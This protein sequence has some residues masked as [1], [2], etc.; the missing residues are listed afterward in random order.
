MKVKW[1]ATALRDVSAHVAYLDQFN[2]H[3]ARELAA[4]TLS[5]LPLRGRRGRATGTRELVAVW[6]YVIVYAIEPDYVKIVR[7]WHGRQIA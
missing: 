7:V 3:A 5:A 2:C 4:G 1:T 6:P